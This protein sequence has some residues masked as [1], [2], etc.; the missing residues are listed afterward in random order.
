MDEV[1]TLLDNLPEGLDLTEVNEAIGALEEDVAAI[2]EDLDGE[3][4]G[5]GGLKDDVAAIQEDIDGEDGIKAGVSAIEEDITAINETLAGVPTE[6]YNALNMRYGTITLNGVN[7]TQVNFIDDAVA[8]YECTTVEPYD[9][10]AGDKVL[11]VNADSNGNEDI[12]FTAVAGTS[13]GDAGASTDISALADNKFLIACDGD[14]TEEVYNEITLDNASCGTGNNTA[15]EMQAKIRLLATTTY[16]DYS[17]VTV[18]FADTKYTITSGTKGTGSKVVIKRATSHNITEELLIGEDGASETTG[19]GV[20]ANSAEAT[21]NEVAEFIN[22][23]A[24]NFT[25]IEDPAGYVTLHGIDTNGS[26]I[27]GADV[28]STAN[29]ILGLTGKDEVI[30]ALGL[31]YTTDMADA[32]YYLSV[33]ASGKAKA[34]KADLCVIGVNAKTTSGFEIVAGADTAAFDVDIIIIGNES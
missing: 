30:G 4:G 26:L 20:G 29:A 18:G 2:Q 7:P 6:A 8:I 24:T 25:A 1:E 9:F 3:G 23:N 10:S 11:R 19:S 27:I 5:G 28:D 13:V 14:A 16:A 32:N 12:T 21:A 33:Q 22:N 31:G 34:D 17:A 15:A